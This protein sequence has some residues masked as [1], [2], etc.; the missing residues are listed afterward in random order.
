METQQL[1]VHIP[2]EAHRELKMRGVVTGKTIREMV[3]EALRNYLR[4]PI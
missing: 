4:E 3:A 2:K 1:L